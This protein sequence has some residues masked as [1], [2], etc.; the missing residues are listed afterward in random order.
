MKSVNIWFKMMEKIKK[1]LKAKMIN[2]VKSNYSNKFRN[3]K[4][5]RRNSKKRKN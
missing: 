5:N 4:K 3:Y 1:K 2:L